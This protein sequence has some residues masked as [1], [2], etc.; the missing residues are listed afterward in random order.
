MELPELTEE[1][2][3]YTYEITISGIT[4]RR[5]QFEWNGAECCT[6]EETALL[7]LPLSERVIES[8]GYEMAGE[9][10]I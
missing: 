8:C 7:H 3:S 2:C 4:L 9:Y 1:F 6:G 5:T 10:E